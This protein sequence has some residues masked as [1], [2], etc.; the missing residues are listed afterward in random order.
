LIILRKGRN[1]SIVIERWEKL[2]NTS[3]E[4]L[5][6][7]FILREAILYFAD[8]SWSLK[9]EQKGYDILLQTLPWAY[10]YIKTPWMKN[11]LSV[12]WI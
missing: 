11:H 3:A 1:S 6:N 8:D 2:K 5:R 9:V 12:E 4:G 7:S 10:G